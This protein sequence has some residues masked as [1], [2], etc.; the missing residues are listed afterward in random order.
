MMMKVNLTHVPYLLFQAKATVY[1]VSYIGVYDIHVP[2]IRLIK[3]N[4]CVGVLK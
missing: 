3:A 4:D 1:K 2:R